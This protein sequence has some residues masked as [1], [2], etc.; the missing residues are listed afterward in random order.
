MTWKTFKEMSLK[1]KLQWLV[2]Y[3]GVVALIIIVVVFVLSNLVKSILFPEPI[4]DV[5]VII[6]SDDIYTEEAI[7]MQYELSKTLDATFDVRS[8]LVSDPYA[9]QSFAT[10]VM[11]DQLDIVVAPKDETEELMRNSYISDYEQINETGLCISIP[12]KARV[13]ESQKQAVKYIREHIENKNDL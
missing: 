9:M 7:E 11:T 8:Y 12:G 4:A 6:L 3:Y 10:R 1:K 5:C 2:Q 13:N